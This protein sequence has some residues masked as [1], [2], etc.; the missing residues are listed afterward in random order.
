MIGALI[1]GI[2]F[3]KTGILPGSGLIGSLNVANTGV[4]FFLYS[5]RMAKK[6]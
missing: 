6:V 2:F 1:S 4:I 3:Q 5:L